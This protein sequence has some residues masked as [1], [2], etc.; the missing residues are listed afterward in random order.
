MKRG[1]VLLLLLCFLPAHNM[2]LALADHAAD[3]YLTPYAEL[4][5]L[6]VGTAALEQAQTS[7]V[8]TVVEVGEIKIE[9][10]QVVCDGDWILTCAFAS[11]DQVLLLPGGATLERPACGEIF[12]SAEAAKA[13]FLELTQATGREIRSVYVYLKEFDSYGL[14]FLDHSIQD[15]QTVLYSGCC[16]PTTLKE[17]TELHWTVQ[18]YAVNM[19]TNQL[20]LMESEEFPVLIVP[21]PTA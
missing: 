12:V 19:D 8:S 9:F 6:P 13:S 2:G 5:Q 3:D 11:S 10:K 21:F 15:D 7:F 1:I 18:I 17:P 4:Y 20:T 14:Y 16:L